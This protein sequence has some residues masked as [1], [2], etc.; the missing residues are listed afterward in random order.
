MCTG[1]SLFWRDIPEQIIEHYHLQDRILVRDEEADREIRFL[2]RERK[3]LL[4]VWH[5]DR[6]DLCRWGTK[7]RPCSLPDT[8]W[9]AWEDIEAGLW[10]ELHPE[11][12][13]IP[14]AFGLDRGVWYQIQE[15]IRG[16]SVTDPNGR[17]HVYM[18]TEPSS[19]YYQV[20][21]RNERMP[22]LIGQRI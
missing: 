10:S 20:M 13:D 1:S 7:D 6:F 2:Y 16:I 15:G 14:A 22:V 18:L 8:G 3:R 11:M 4:P 21:T 12:V 17:P 19:H 5:H 9:V